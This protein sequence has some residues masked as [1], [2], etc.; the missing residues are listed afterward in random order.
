MGNRIDDAL[1]VLHSREQ[2]RVENLRAAEKFEA[3]KIQAQQQQALAEKEQKRRQKVTDLNSQVLERKFA[4]DTA[5]E[6]LQFEEGQAIG[7]TPSEATFQLPEVSEEF[8]GPREGGII[9]RQDTSGLAGPF[10]A[11]AF[12][13]EDRHN[14]LI[15]AFGINQQLQAM[16][17]QQETLNSPQLAAAKVRAGIDILQEGGKNKRATE[18]ANAVIKGQEARAQGV[19]DAAALK[20]KSENRKIQIADNRVRALYDPIYTGEME[21]DPTN[22]T[23]QDVLVEIKKS[24]GTIFP[25]KTVDVL[26][27]WGNSMNI[28]MKMKAASIANP[29]LFP[30]SE[31]NAKARRLWIQNIVANFGPES[32]AAAIEYEKF[33]G[34]PAIFVQSITGQPGSRVSDNEQ[35]TMQKALGHLGNPLPIQLRLIDDLTDIVARNII[36]QSSEVRK[37]D[38][39]NFNAK[40]NLLYGE[41]PDLLEKILVKDKKSKARQL[42]S[43]GAELAK[44]IPDVLPEG[45]K[46]MEIDGVFGVEDSEGN[47]F[48]S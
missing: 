24:G 36:I 2:L 17:Q 31:L 6:R 8:T 45:F 44:E 15:Q 14:E 33:E 25:K 48:P 42:E 18:A 38:P 41:Y 28:L 40:M 20:L 39:T 21:F 47:F 5:V 22:S 1:G 32:S 43:R 26:K 3:D 27:D 13:S 12:Q 29:E 23:M 4:L 11:P 10:G 7:R 16:Q 35:R 19:R 9:G 46:Y 37:K 34:F 30:E